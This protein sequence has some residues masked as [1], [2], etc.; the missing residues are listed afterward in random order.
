MPRC[1]ALPHDTEV[2]KYHQV[3]PK[4]RLSGD[5]IIRAIAI[6]EGRSWEEVL[7]DM[8]EKSV[9]LGYLPVDKRF[10]TRYLKDRGWLKQSQ[11]VKPDGT[12]YL[13]WEFCKTIA[14]SLRGCTDSLIVNIGSYYVTTIV[15]G[16]I[17]DTWDCSGRYVGNYWIY[18]NPLS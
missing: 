14:K 6:A 16:V 11:P 8:T 10:Y 3:N 13:G 4:D 7:M 1:R 2:F 18:P 9:S 17:H 15:D 12:K 5:A